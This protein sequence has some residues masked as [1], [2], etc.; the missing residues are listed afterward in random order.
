MNR[1]SFVIVGLICAAVGSAW[2]SPSF[3]HV[4]LLHEFS[5]ERN[6]VALFQDNFSDGSPPPS[7]PN[8]LNGFP[9]SYGTSGGLSEAGNHLIMDTALGAPPS[10]LF[11]GIPPGRGQNVTLLTRN[12]TTC[13]PTD[14]GLMTGDTFKVE[15]IFD[16][17]LPVEPLARYG[18][19]FSDRFTLAAPNN[20]PPM[21]AG[22]DV[23]ELS[24]QRG[25]DGIMRV[26]YRQRD[27][28]T[29]TLTTIAEVVLTP[30]PGD[31]HIL[32]RLERASLASNDITASFDLGDIDLLPNNPVTFSY[33]FATA[34]NPDATIFNGEN[35]T[36]PGV[37]ASETLVPEPGTLGL[38]ALALVPLG[39]ARRKRR[40]EG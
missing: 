16:L 25:T 10:V 19:Q 12:R 32:L 24:V 2:V 17:T 1:Y 18:V 35:W 31:D 33:V 3:A 20:D 21:S 11:P 26:R 23:L 4:V 40:L 39:A 38:L 30:E 6:G 9:A 8:F 28:T 27:F 22:D 36:R 14:T 5:V 7:A 34:G 29:L 13:C 15:A 37:F